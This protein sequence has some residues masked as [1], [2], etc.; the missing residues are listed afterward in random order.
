M[1]GATMDDP[2][3]VSVLLDVRRAR[4]RRTTLVLLTVAGLV[5]PFVAWLAPTTRPYLATPSSVGVVLAGLAVLASCVAAM[6]SGREPQW[7]LPDDIAWAFALLTLGLLAGA[8]ASAVPAILALHALALVLLGVRVPPGRMIVVASLSAALPFL[9][10]LVMRRP[11]G[12][13]AAALLVSA[14]AQTAHSYLARATHSLAYLLAE[15]ENLL[16]ERK[17]VVSRARERLKTLERQARDREDT[18]EVLAVPRLFQPARSALIDTED[19]AGW[20]SL[21]ERMRTSLSAQCE[22]VGVEATVSAELR[23]LAPPSSKLRQG[24]LKIAQEAAANAL[25]DAAPRSVAVTLRRADGGLILE[26]LDDGEEGEESRARRSITNLRGR[27][28]PLGG[29]AELR[30]ADAGWMVRVKLPCD[31]LN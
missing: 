19:D 24:V 17:G 26:V 11:L 20:E 29:S 28:V 13:V 15:R 27:V 7:T 16:A 31:Q 1:S 22:P 30:R 4:Q 23:G 25:R 18:P 21:V 14:V 8:S 2:S 10:R 5:L 6:W 9:M 12:D 3:M